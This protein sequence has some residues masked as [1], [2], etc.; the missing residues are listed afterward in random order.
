METNEEDIIWSGHPSQLLNF[1]THFVSAL[2]VIGIVVAAILTGIWLLAVLV[3][4]PIGWS[5][6]KYLTIRCRVYQLTSE[7]LRLF[8]GVLNQ[9]IGEVE[10]YR[11]KDTN[12]LRPFWLRV[13]GLSTIKADTSDRTHPVVTLEAIRD[14]VRVRELFRKQVEILRDK[15]RV[16]EVDFDGAGDGDELEFES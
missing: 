2:V 5:V 12:I 6:W 16:R 11:V 4:L 13:F 14:G 7:R 1:W 9:E 15:K 3:I 10:L 8:E